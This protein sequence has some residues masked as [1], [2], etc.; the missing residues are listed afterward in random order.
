[1][2][3]QEPAL[4]IMKTGDYGT[5]KSYTVQCSCGSPDDELKFEV[6]SDELGISVLTYTTQ[7][8]DWWTDTYNQ[9]KAY[10]FKNPILF[11]INYVGRGL[12]NS[13]AHRLK[14]TYNIWVKGYLEYEQCTMMSEQQALNYTNT[15][16]TAMK[17]VGAVHK[18]KG[19]SKKKKTNLTELFNEVF[20][21]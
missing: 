21:K 17:D 9:N 10:E 12:L 5:C 3:A 20:S 19:H 2:K 15:L 6:E 18:A 13:I 11:Q 16:I 7:K 8:T 1:M 4:G 14:L